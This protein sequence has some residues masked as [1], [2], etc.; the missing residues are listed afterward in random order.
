LDRVEVYKEKK[1][2]RLKK[3]E[4]DLSKGLTFKPK[5]Y[6]KNNIANKYYERQMKKI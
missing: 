1:D 2:E 3:L 4:D 5:T 6:S